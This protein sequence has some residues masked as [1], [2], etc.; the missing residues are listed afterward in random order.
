M[1]LARDVTGAATCFYV[2]ESYLDGSVWR[3]RDLFA[4]GEDPS[5]WIHYPG[6]N[7]YYVDTAVEDALR[8]GGIAPSQEDLEDLFWPFLAPRV[9]E[10]IRSF[11]RRGRQTRF[12]R[13][14][15][16]QLEAM[17]RGVHAFDKRRLYFLR[18]G[19]AD[20]AKVVRFPIRLYNRVLE[21]SRDEIEQML[22]G[23]EDL[24]R[25]TERKAYIYMAFD[26]SRFFRSPLATAY[27]EAMDPERMDEA[28]LDEVCRLQADPLLF[29]TEASPGTLHPALVRYVI[30]YFDNE[31]RPHDWERAYVEDFIRRHRSPPRRPARRPHLPV[32]VACK[33]LGITPEVYAGLDARALAQHYRKMA[34]DLHP[35][36]GGSHDGFIRLTHA[37][38]DLL[39]RKGLPR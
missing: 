24:L 29:R 15:R 11:G 25:P 12:R 33:A 37:Y 5:R 21:K 34:L 13:Y 27:P 2:R 28:F 36:R 23:M 14:S 7:A 16:A 32:E 6:G 35:D 4:L 1:Y 39:A 22:H 8:A 31:F 10:T 17:Q 9:R 3:S 19:N 26:L 18:Y 38:R 30:Q 20:P